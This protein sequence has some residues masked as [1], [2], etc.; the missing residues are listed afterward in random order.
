MSALVGAEFLKFRT[1]RAWIGFLLAAVALTAI[2]AAGTVGTARDDQL[3]TTQLSRDIVS[4]SLFTALIALMIGIMSV[5]AEWRHGTVTRTFLV[6]PRRE[7]VLIAKELWV[8]LLAAALAVLAIVLVLAIAVPW[9]AVEG[10]SL[11]LDGGVAGLV[12]RIV[13]ASVLWGTLGVG[14]GAVVQ[15]QTF[16]LVGAVIWIIVVEALIIALLRLVD[17][18]GVGEYLPGRALSSFD[19]TEEGG[20]TTWAAGAVS[21]AWVLALGL[22][23]YVR[24]SRGMSPRLSAGTLRVRTLMPRSAR[25][26]AVAMIME[27]PGDNGFRPVMEHLEWSELDCR[28][29]SSRLRGAGDACCFARESQETPSASSNA[30]P[31]LV[32][33]VAPPTSR[34]WLTPQNHARISCASTTATL[35]SHGRAGSQRRRARALDRVARVRRVTASH[36]TTASSS[37]C[38]AGCR[39]I[40]FAR[41]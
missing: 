40:A 41:V 10:S 7:R 34:H 21:L 25:V 2:A 14:V 26:T 9:L 35:A 33:G 37:S 36:D 19:G 17:L 3:G 24:M 20:L 39:A 12:G 22:L 4:T 31:S 28:T 30:S 15:S 1:T 38:A 16:A 11:K 27:R 8:A 13:I 23:G 29:A 6:T 18:E 5:T 32:P